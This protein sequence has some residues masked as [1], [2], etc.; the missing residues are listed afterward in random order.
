M[1]LDDLPRIKKAWLHKDPKVSDL[2][3]HARIV[4]SSSAVKCMYGK[5]VLNVLNL[6]VFVD[7]KLDDNFFLS[8]E[9]TK[10]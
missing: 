2:Q 3:A 9:K 8:L 7:K 4:Q 5:F 1:D 10:V 6:S